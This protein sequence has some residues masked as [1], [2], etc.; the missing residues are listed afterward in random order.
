ML[1]PGDVLDNRYQ[2]ES[3]LAKGGMGAVFLAGDR[4]LGGKSVAIKEIAMSDSRAFLEEARILA[5]LQHPNIPK[6]TDYYEP[7]DN[8]N[9]YL[10][11]DYIR[12][13][14][15]Q[16]KFDNE[17]RRLS[18][19]AVLTYADQIC[20]ILEYLHRQPTPIIFRDLKPSNMMIDELDRVQ[21]IDFGI[22]R[23]YE[24]AKL[25][26]TVQMG[27][28]AFAAPEQFENRQTDARTDIYGIGSILFYLLSGGKFVYQNRDPIDVALA[29][30]PDPIVRAI[31]RM[32]DPDP[33]KRFSSAA[34]AKRALSSS[35]PMPGAG[36]MPNIRTA[37]VL[38]RTVSL[39]GVA[40]A[41]IPIAT[42][43]I[44]AAM[45]TAHLGSLSIGPRASYS[46]KAT[47]SQPALVIYLL[48][49]SGSMD[50]MLGGRRRIDVV[51]ESLHVA[52]RQMVFRSTKGSRIASRYRVAIIAYSDES[53]DL[54]GGP[55]NIDEIMSAGTLPAL[56][57]Q[58]FTDTA[59][60]FLHA[61][62]ILKEELPRIQDGPAPLICH[63]TDGA[64]TGED[65][66]PIARRIMGMSVRDGNVL[67]ENIFISDDLL[68]QAIDQPKRWVGVRDDTEFRDD[69][70]HK[71]KRMSSVIPESYRSMIRESHYNL[72]A[73]SLL[74]FPGTT[75]DLVSLGFQMSA[76]TP[77][78]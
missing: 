24:D 13:S 23:R 56:G 78:H 32:L 73:G 57:I 71:L 48:D 21:L 3:M 61:E 8:G 17:G 49:V 38:D 5:A 22:A 40:P 33:N 20:D 11:M 51:T 65:P 12:G 35:S 54:L 29:G 66:E 45:A 34:E 41:Q 53:R 39:S 10:V 69:Y 7:D 9:C 63:M 19:S 52:L 58:R 44:P 68:V 74:M 77:I 15:L 30:V 26:D 67:I 27:T 55:K 37:P 47:Q 2:I 70:G 36:D 75:P 64:Y 6:I 14:T 72:A 4:K 42:A 76:A 50:L 60:A 16:H 62:R 46:V 18:L 59:Q 25:T 43:S 28:I 1:Q 31:E